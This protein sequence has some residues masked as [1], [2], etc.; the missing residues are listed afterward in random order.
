MARHGHRT[1]TCARYADGR[2]TLEMRRALVTPAGEA[3]DVQ[4]NDLS[5]SYEF[6]VAI[7][8]NSQINHASHET[9]L[10]LTFGP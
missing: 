5:K 9:V 3:E 10:R 4:F 2:W 6:G 1:P 8:D 7:F